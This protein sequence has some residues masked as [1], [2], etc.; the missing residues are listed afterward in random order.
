MFSWGA[1][2]VGGSSVNLGE[3]VFSWESNISW[4]RQCSDG[5]CH[6]VALLLALAV[7]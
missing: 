2:L 1:M 7:R 6:C 5:L 4:G 3:A